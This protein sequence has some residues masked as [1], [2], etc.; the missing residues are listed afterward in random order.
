MTVV[1][2]TRPPNGNSRVKL[3]VKHSVPVTGSGIH[4]FFDPWIRYSDRIFGWKRSGFGIRDFRALSNI[5][6]GLKKLNYFFV[7]PD[8]GSGSFLTLDPGM[9]KFRSRQNIPEPQH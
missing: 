6:L 5:F 7:D 3:L 8:R 1:P 9:E 4:C 2:G